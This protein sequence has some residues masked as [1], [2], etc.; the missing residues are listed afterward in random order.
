MVKNSN[1]K[2]FVLISA[3]FLAIL[4]FCFNSTSAQL[5]PISLDQR[6]DNSTAI[7]EGKV[8]RQTSYWD[9]TKT[10]IYT[11]NIVEVYKVFKGESIAKE[12]ELI[13]RGGI[14]GDNMQRVS[15]NLVLNIGDAGVFTAV[16]NT[17]KLVTNTKL[18]QL[19]TYAGEQGFI[20]YDQ[21]TGSAK[22]VFD[23]YNKITTDVHA[24]IVARTK[25]NIKIIQKSNLKVQ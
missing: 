1:Q 9:N 23:T 24:K 14:V 16:V 6:I 15:H 13:T 18:T 17:A 7:F 2:L 3:G 10:H 12:I 11:S 22:D 19:K 5:I 4:L 21:E 8:I 25:L 20:K